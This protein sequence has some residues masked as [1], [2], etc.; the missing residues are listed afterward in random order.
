M[1]VWMAS[2]F[3]CCQ[4]HNHKYDPFTQKEY[5]Q[6]Y[7]VFNSTGDKN[8][9]DDAPTVTVPRYGTE[10]QWAELQPKYDAAKAALDELTR[11][12]DAGWK[13]WTASVDP[14]SLPPEIAAIHAKAPKER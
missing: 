9:G 2:T 5:F 11:T 8:T 4:C 1:K 3:A 12:V 6:L 13:E 7:A 10:R 14:R